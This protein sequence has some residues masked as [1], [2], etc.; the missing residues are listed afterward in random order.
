MVHTDWPQIDYEHFGGVS[1]EYCKHACL[2][3]CFCSV[4][5]YHNEECWKKRLP[6]TNGRNDPS[7][8]DKTLIKLSFSFTKVQPHRV[9][10]TMN[11]QN[12]TY[13]KLEKI[14]RGFK[15]EL[16]NGAFGTVYKG[17]LAS[18]NNKFVAVKKLDNAASEESET[19]PKE[20]NASQPKP[21]HNSS[22]IVMFLS[23]S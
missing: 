10:S 13:N 20:H 2:S 12:F 4:V 16:G 7:I 17:V 3:D 5:M 8:R 14:T 21:A 15:E 22:N 11:L 9:M 19:K 6:L 23:H 18:K 1:E